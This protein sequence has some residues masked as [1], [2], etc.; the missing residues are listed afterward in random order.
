MQL[1]KEEYRDATS[2]IVVIVLT[3]LPSLRYVLLMHS[4]IEN[5]ET[6][7]EPERTKLYYL[8]KQQITQQMDIVSLLVCAFH[9]L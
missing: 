7:S 5:T 6:R 1:K 8:Q 2:Q 3:K 4:I 9:I